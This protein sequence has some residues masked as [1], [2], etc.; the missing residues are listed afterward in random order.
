M[1]LLFWAQIFF[2]RWQPRFIANSVFF[3]LPL[4]MLVINC[5]SRLCPMRFYLE[6]ETFI[7]DT[8]QQFGRGA[9]DWDPNNDDNRFLNAT[10][11]LCHMLKG[12]FTVARFRIEFYMT[13]DR[14]LMTTIVETLLNFIPLYRSFKIINKSHNE[15]LSSLPNNTIFNV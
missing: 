9:I 15:F 1:F 5:L 4:A 7:I 13:G 11:C 3:F 6:V 2:H 8:C 14:R 10:L 12:L